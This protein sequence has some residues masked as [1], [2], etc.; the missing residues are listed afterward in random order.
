MAERFEAFNTGMGLVQAQ[1]DDSKENVVRKNIVVNLGNTLSLLPN[2]TSTFSSIRNISLT[3]SPHLDPTYTIPQMPS[4]YTPNQVAITPNPQL[5]ITTTQFEKNKKNELAICPYRRPGK[6]I[7]SLCHEDLGKELH[8]LRKAIN[9]ELCSRNFQSLKYEDLCVHPNVELPPG[10]KIPKFNTFNGEGDPIAH[11]KDYCSRLIGIGH[12]EAVRMRLFI[13]S[14]SGSALSW[15][16]KQDFS[17]WHTWEDMA[18]E[19]IKQFEFNKGGDPHIADLL[20]VKKMPHESFQE[21]AIRWRLEASKMHPPL[22]ERELISTFVQTQ[23][24]LYYDKLLGA[25]ARNFSDLIR[26]GK[27]LESGIKEGRITD[28]TA[29]QAIHQTFQSKIPRNLQ[30]EMKENKFASM[31]MHQ[32]QCHQSHQILQSYATMQRPR[33]QKSQHGCQQSFHQAQ[34]SSRQQK[35]MKSFS[36]TPLDEPLSNILERLSAKGI[37]QP[38]K[39]FIPKHPPPNFDLSKSCAYHSNIQGH[40]TEECLALRF[41]I[42]SMI[43]NGKIKLQQEPPTGNDNIANTNAITVKGDPSKLAPRPLKRKRAT[44]QED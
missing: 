36:F 6:E 40:D 7:K 27:E 2:T 43:E 9:E 33:Q 12:N 31:S 30:S 14:L 1:N 35:K 16:T 18:R 11:L 17:K 15:Y 4:T 26:I 3:I 24:D 22:P 44:T 13:Q 8:N 38:K 29:T 32:A 42:Q 19:F 21:Y 25:C 10:Y 37:L 34:S 5:S 28:S 39:G 20:R 23:E 41:K